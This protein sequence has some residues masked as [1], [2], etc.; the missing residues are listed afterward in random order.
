MDY[1]LYCSEMKRFGQEVTYSEAEYNAKYGIESI[2]TMVP[3][4]ITPRNQQRPIK[5]TVENKVA[6]GEKVKPKKTRVKMVVKQPS[7]PRVLYTAEEM[8]KRRADSMR[9]KRK[10]FVD[11]GLTV[12]G[13]ARVVK[14][15][16]KRTIEE[17]RAIRFVYAKTW[18]E[19]NREEYLE[20]R[21]RLY[22]EKQQRI[23]ENATLGIRSSFQRIEPTSK[24]LD[25]DDKAVFGY[26]KDIERN[27]DTN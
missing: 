2:D 4:V 1:Q 26:R 17:I 8:R 22:R 11:S 24:M 18:R 25:K 6:I 20:Y 10:A 19:K 27:A 9:A 13:K 5:A 14:E 3:I 23:I 15:K 21:R 7:P 16:V 12:R